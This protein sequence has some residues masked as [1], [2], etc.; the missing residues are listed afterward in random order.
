MQ[1]F[2]GRFAVKLLLIIQ[3]KENYRLTTIIIVLGRLPD[4]FTDLTFIRNTFTVVIVT[5]R[6][7]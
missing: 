2:V 5:I 1:F 4:N 3:N 6:S 7:V